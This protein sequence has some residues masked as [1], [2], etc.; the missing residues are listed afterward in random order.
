MF[1]KKYLKNEG[2][3]LIEVMIVVAMVGVLSAIA[4]P[5]FKKFQSK[6]RSSEARIE[7]A[8]A[9]IAETAFYADFKIYHTCLA[10]MGYNPSSKLET[11]HYAIG[12]RV[13]PNIDNTKYAEATAAG[14]IP[15][16][17]PDGGSDPPVGSN[18]IRFIGMNSIGGVAMTDPIYR[19]NAQPINSSL[20]TKSD[21][22]ANVSTY[23]HCVGTQADDERSTF[24]LPAVGIIDSDR[25]A[26]TEVSIWTVN[27]D[28][29][30]TNIRAGY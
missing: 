10:Y 17:C 12:F 15:T 14:L 16:L 2:F 5:S 11:M 8:S 1:D 19:L 6:S 21:I 4:Y 13:Y 3:T 27:Q 20:C 24:V 18:L 23:V 25:T 29:R 26:P 22:E 30:F 9:Y 28:K 7:L